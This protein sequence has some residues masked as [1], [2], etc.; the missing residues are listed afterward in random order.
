M[1]HIGF[2]GFHQIGNKIVATFELYFDLRE[3][4]LITIPQAD[5]LIKNTDTVNNQYRNYNQN[6]DCAH[7]HTRNLPVRRNQ[8]T[9][10]EHP[11]LTNLPVAGS[12]CGS[13]HQDLALLVSGPAKAR[14]QCIC[15]AAC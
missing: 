11:G 14:F 10:N 5:Q 6:D 7:F 15:F 2:C 1:G 3:C 9:Q 4:V 8:G 13:R 12:R